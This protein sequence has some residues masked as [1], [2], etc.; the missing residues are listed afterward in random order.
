MKIINKIPLSEVGCT[1]VDVDDNAHFL[2]A[3]DMAY[4]GFSQESAIIPSASLWPWSA[5]PKN[6]ITD[7]Y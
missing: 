1:L 6:K 7:I 5:F 2:A 4:V 3:V